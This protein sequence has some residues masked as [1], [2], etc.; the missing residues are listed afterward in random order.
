MAPPESRPPSAAR[1]FAI[2][3]FC[4]ARFIKGNRDVLNSQT[5]DFSCLRR[6]M[7]IL[8]YGYQARRRRERKFWIYV[9]Y[10]CENRAVGA[11]KNV[12]FSC[13][14]RVKIEGIAS[15]KVLIMAPQANS[16]I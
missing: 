8:Y 7:V 9:L 6:K 11:R 15:E 16:R 5:P 2:L 1:K 12:I 4:L 3:W 14:A 10:R 13:I